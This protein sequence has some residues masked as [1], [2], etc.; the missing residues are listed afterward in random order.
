MLRKKSTGFTLIELLV[1][2]SIIGLLSSMV[3]ASVR[4]GKDKAYTS[5]MSQSINNYIKALESYRLDNSLNGFPRAEFN[6]PNWVPTRC[7]GYGPCIYQ[8]SPRQV[9]QAII[10]KLKPYINP[11]QPSTRIIPTLFSDW[12]GITYW[13]Y[14]SDPTDTVCKTIQLYWAIPSSSASDCSISGLD[15]V[16]PI[17]NSCAAGACICR[18][19]IGPISCPNGYI[20]Y[21]GTP[22]AHNVCP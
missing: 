12:Q 21:S 15:T 3:L 1:V 8:G 22:D 14:Y 6:N 10:D 5:L 18:G 9:D 7:L 17:P 13:C 16:L 11:V 4:A 19:W 20:K 2:I